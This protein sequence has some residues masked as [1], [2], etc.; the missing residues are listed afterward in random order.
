M[1][2]RWA[3]VHIWRRSTLIYREAWLTWWSI[4]M[5]WHS[6]SSHRI[7]IIIKW[8]WRRHSLHGILLT[9]I[10]VRSALVTATTTI[11]V[12]LWSACSCWMTVLCTL[13]TSWRRLASISVIT[14]SSSLCCIIQF[15]RSRK[16]VLSLHFC[17]CCLSLLLNSKSEETKAFGILSHRVN[18]DLGLVDWRELLRKDSN[19]QLV[20]HIWV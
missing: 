6:I 12:A 14:W 15:D 4:L 16:N 13:K 19:Q 3:S 2:R 17:Y 1:R 18:N 8:R 5:R 11:I 20:V 7:S 10:H 9:S